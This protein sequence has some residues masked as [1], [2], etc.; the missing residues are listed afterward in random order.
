MDAWTLLSP[1]QADASRRL[2]AEETA[3]RRHVV[4]SLSGAHAYGFPSP[5][6]DVDLK[7][8]HLDPA[9]RFLGLRAE[10]TTRERLEWID[11]I[12]VDYSSNELGGVLAGILKGNGNYLERIAGACTLEAGEAL[13]E[14]RAAVLRNLSRRVHN[15]YR[16]FA[17]SQ[18]RE[19]ESTGKA[20]KALYVLRT[21]LTGRRLLLT[22]EV[23]T[24][25]TQ[26]LDEAGFPEGRELV[27]R[28][29]SG[30]QAQLPFEERAR[31]DAVLDRAFVVLDEALER[32]P[33]PPEPAHAD[34]LDALL[35]S[36][37]L[38]HLEE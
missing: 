21:T 17:F 8:V 5:D 29:L 10:P 34:A 4:V 7:A 12:E 9:R 1:A 11:G 35:V 23:V 14:I 15:H 2:L 18:R 25:V 27:A 13:A 32:S 20:K 38:R 22:G 30:E 6:S 37:R 36:L 24:D 33:L 3:R 19:W 28:K 26:L 31:W 16:G